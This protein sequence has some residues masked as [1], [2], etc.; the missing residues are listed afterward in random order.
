MWKQLSQFTQKQVKE[1]AD[2]FSKF[3]T[4]RV[5]IL[6]KD[7]NAQTCDFLGNWVKYVDLKIY[8]NIPDA[9]LNFKNFLLALNNGDYPNASIS[10]MRILDIFMM[11]KLSFSQEISNML[12]ENLPVNV[13]INC[14]RV[15]INN[16]KISVNNLC[17]DNLQEQI[18]QVNAIENPWLKMIDIQYPQD[19][20]SLNTFMTELRKPVRYLFVKYPVDEFM[21]NSLIEDG[22]LKHIYGFDER[23]GELLNSITVTGNTMHL[24][25]VS[26]GTSEDNPEIQNMISNLN[27][28]FL[29]LLKSVSFNCTLK[30]DVQVYEENI[31]S[32]YELQFTNPQFVIHVTNEVY[33][34]QADKVWIKI[35]DKWHPVSYEESKE[36]F[37]NYSNITFGRIFKAEITNPK[38]I[39]MHCE[40]TNKAMPGT[41][42]VISD[43]Y[44][45]KIHVDFKQQMVEYK[46]LQDQGST[47]LRQTPIFANDIS[48][49]L[50]DKHEDKICLEISPFA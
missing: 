5:S 24:N 44:L 39:K 47:I 40:D 28:I 9:M 34:M 31:N 38:V 17:A 35:A 12:I 6:V 27:I 10:D 45:S 36:D 2:F 33:V 41:Q 4:N 23:V 8:L 46:D 48:T 7:W 13:L 14:P 18:D 20:N 21:T 15:L 22:S 32:H 1:N 25:N 30:L 42:L 49:V 3:L 26:Y 11:S 19:L 43:K 50:I 37:G 16:K 29:H